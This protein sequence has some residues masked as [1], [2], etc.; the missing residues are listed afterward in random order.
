MDTLRPHRG[1]TEQHDSQNK[2]VLVIVLAIVSVGLFPILL[3]HAPPAEVYSLTLSSNRVQEYDAP[4]VTLFLNV[5]SASVGSNYNFTFTVADPTGATRNASNATT[6]IVPSFITSVVYPRD[7]GTGTSIKYVGN[8][9]INIQQNKPTPKPGP[10]GRFL[11]GLTDSL[12]YQRTDQVSI[13]ATGYAPLESVTISLF[14]GAVSAPGFPA[15][16]PTDGA[17]RIAFPWQIP[18]DAATGTYTVTLA[19]STTIKSPADAQTFTVYPAN[20]TIAGITV[21]SPTISRTLTEQ[22]LFAPQYPNGQR[23]QT[24][25]ATVR[26]AESDGVTY[27]SAIGAFD[28]LTG[29]FRATYRIPR[30]ATSGI[31]VATIDADRFDDGYGNAGPALTIAAGFYVQPASLDVS[32]TA[33]SGNSYAAGQSIPI[34][35]SVKYPDGAVFSSGTVVAKFSH[36]GLVIGTPIAL[37]YISG[38]QEWAGSYQVNP[39]D[40]PGLWLVT[41]D[42]S[43]QPGNSGEGTSSSVVSIPPPASQP[44]QPTTLNSSSFLLMAAAA[45]SGALATLVMA[46]LVSRRKV[47]RSEVKLDLRVVDKEVDRIQDSTFFKSVKKQVEDKRASE[48]ENPGPPGSEGDPPSH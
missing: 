44:P 14:H 37:T 42:A 21:I 31:W 34:Y 32:V 19:G 22:F 8:Y 13:K 38:Q 7:F 1:E 27:V 46:F 11:V 26:I 4:G 15:S 12:S 5:S 25:Q 17:G 29:T 24:G 23:V 2:A 35:A 10:T 40:P 48:S 3:A 9:T 16:Q 45:A 39:S 33:P 41:V 43:D 28:S 30:D 18:P 36:S 47:T 20:V 6:P